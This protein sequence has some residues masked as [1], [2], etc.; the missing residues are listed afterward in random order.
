MLNNT[1]TQ[2][3]TNHVSYR[4]KSATL[5]ECTHKYTYQPLPSH[6]LQQQYVFNTCVHFAYF[7]CNLYMVI[8]L[9][10]IYVPH[11]FR[12]FPSATCILKMSR[13][14]FRSSPEASAYSFEIRHLLMPFCSHAHARLTLL[15]HLP[16]YKCTYMCIF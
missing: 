7:C 5:A 8:F 14:F 1:D 2:L 15:P 12:H 10:H 13:C 3:S 6:L 9:S 16:T 4:F 11:A